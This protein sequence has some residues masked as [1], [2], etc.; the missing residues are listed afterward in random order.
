VVD[1]ATCASTVAS[2]NTPTYKNISF[3]TDESGISKTDMHVG[4][5][6]PDPTDADA[7]FITVLALHG[8]PQASGMWFQNFGT[9]LLAKFQ[10]AKRKARLVAPDL[11]GVG[12][13]VP[14][15]DC[16]D[17]GCDNYKP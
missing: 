10:T 7:E 6:G 8:F 4:Q 5:L 13:T 12:Q 16:V 15:Y 1:D 11:R 2:K 17:M 3:A 9:T 14:K